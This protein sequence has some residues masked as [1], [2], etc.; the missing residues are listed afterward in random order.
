M[1]GGITKS[2][3][4]MMA[5]EKHILQRNIYKYYLHYL[6]CS[7]LCVP[8]ALLGIMAVLVVKEKW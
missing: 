8:R 7:F 5:V 3:Q 1:V 4:Y 6:I 2:L